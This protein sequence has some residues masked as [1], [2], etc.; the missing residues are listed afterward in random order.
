MIGLLLHAREQRR[1][2]VFTVHERPDPPADRIDLPEEL[3]FV[4][5]GFAWGVA[6]FPPLVFAMRGQWLALGAYI[7]AAGLLA[8][9]MSLAGASNDWIGLAI[10]GLNI[11]TGLEAS[12]IERAILDRQGFIEVGTVSGRNQNDCERRFFESWIT[13]Q[14]AVSVARSAPHEAPAASEGF[15]ASLFSRLRGGLKA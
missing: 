11:F 7:V 3:V 9:L 1:L 4:K 8:G 14:P 13:G 12:T 5:D 10:L 6:A 15:A 2:D